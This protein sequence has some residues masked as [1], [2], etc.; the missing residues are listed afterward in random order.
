[1][2]ELNNVLHETAERAV[3]LTTLAI[4]VFDRKRRRVSACSFGQTRPRYLSYANQWQELSCEVH[5][6]LGL[7]VSQSFAATSVLLALGSQWLLLTD[8]FVEAR[9]NFG[10]QFGEKALEESLFESARDQNN[11]LTILEKRWREFSKNGPEADDATAMLV[12]DTSPHP[13]ANCECE[14]SPESISQLRF[15]CEDWVKF[16]GFVEAETYNIVL[17]CDEVFTNV[18]KHAYRGTSGP[19]RCDA[20]AN[21]KTLTFVLTHHGHGLN[22]DADLP[23]SSTPPK[24][25]GHGLPFI[26]RVFDDVKFETAGEC[27]KVTLTKCIP[28]Q[29]F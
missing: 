28:R 5:S 9:N 20:S 23:R 10:V 15:F 12:T 19:V 21:Q 26:R 2:A 1:L 22:P 16:V 17:A 24:I 14:I 4:M 25:G 27:S 8:G 3:S 29:D 6:P 11:P 7:L 18:Y 13:P